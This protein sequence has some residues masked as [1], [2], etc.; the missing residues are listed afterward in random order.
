MHD[1]SGRPTHRGLIHVIQF[2]SRV[3]S[4]KRRTWDPASFSASPAFRSLHWT[5][6]HMVAIFEVEYLPHSQQLVSSPPQL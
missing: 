1:S 4:W 6:S 3:N 5:T 2:V